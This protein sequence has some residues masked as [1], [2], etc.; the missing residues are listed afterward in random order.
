MHLKKI[1]RKLLCPDRGTRNFLEEL[2]ETAKT[3]NKIGGV[4]AEIRTG[5]L[6]NKCIDLPLY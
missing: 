5:N 4:P 3:L 2:K 6:H 1:G